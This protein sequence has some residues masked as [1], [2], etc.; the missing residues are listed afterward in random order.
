MTHPKKRFLPKGWKCKYL[1]SLASTGVVRYSA[2]QAGISVKTVNRHR[3]ADPAFDAGCNAAIEES[4]EVLELAARKRAVRGVSKP[5]YQ[6]GIQVGSVRE[7][8]DT[9]LIFL[10]KGNMPEK[11]RERHSYEVGGPGGAPLAA[12]FTATLDTVYPAEPAAE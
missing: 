11:Y 5:V 4:C 3:K 10:M 12:E 2:K 6:G 1:T 8:S 7:Y 9:L